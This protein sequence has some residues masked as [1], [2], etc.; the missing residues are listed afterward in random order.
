[1]GNLDKVFLS[2]MGIISCSWK[3]RF[4]LDVGCLTKPSNCWGVAFLSDQVLL[5]D[6]EKRVVLPIMENLPVVVSVEDV[7]GY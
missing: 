3:T 1:M 5:G 4:P 6:L 2:C 7:S